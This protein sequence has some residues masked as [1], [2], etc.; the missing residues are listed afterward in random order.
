MSQVHFPLSEWKQCFK[1]WNDAQA[2]N[3]D[4]QLIVSTNA[5]SQGYWIEDKGTE[6]FPEK[7]DHIYTGKQVDELFE[8]VKSAIDNAE[9][10]GTAPGLI[11]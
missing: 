8:R 6:Y 10:T 4:W 1:H 9:K 7:G 2:I 5:H 3:D 11:L